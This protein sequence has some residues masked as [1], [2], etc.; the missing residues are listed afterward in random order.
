[1]ISL[2]VCSVFIVDAFILIMNEAM[3]VDSMHK[4][5]RFTGTDTPRYALDQNHS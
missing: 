1:M 5:N 4:I 3:V 2:L